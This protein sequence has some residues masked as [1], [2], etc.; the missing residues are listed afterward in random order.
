MRIWA[1]AC[2]ALLL[3]ACAGWLEVLTGPPEIAPATPATPRPPAPVPGSSAPGLR[4]P[5]PPPAPRTPAPAPRAPTP[6]PAPEAPE[7]PAPTKVER[8]PYLVLIPDSEVYYAPEHPGGLFFYNGLWYTRKAGR[9]FSSPGF[10]GPWKSLSPRGVP[11]PLQH[12]PA[13]PEAPPP[14]RRGSAG[15]G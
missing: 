9:W 10:S 15:P 12:L 4:T 11:S 6:A 1:V 8:P 13:S 3:A 7:P 5:A 14:P 2:G